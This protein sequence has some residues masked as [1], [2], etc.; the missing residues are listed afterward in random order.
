MHLAEV[1]RDH[2]RFICKPLTQLRLD[3]RLLTAA[4][5]RQKYLKRIQI[6]WRILNRRNSHVN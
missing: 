6:R 2:P 3:Y 5:H 4:N 1:A